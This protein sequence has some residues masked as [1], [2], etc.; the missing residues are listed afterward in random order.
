MCA[1]EKGDQCPL[2]CVELAGASAEPI[3]ANM[4]AI[5]AFIL[6]EGCIPTALPVIYLSILI[7]VCLY[8]YLYNFVSELFVASVE[9]CKNT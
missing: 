1:K 2:E 5:S 9:F 3:M 7:S 4:Q 6:Q 8:L